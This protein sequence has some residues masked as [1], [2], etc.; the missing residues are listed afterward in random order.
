MS[1]EIDEDSR[2]SAGIF[3]AAFDLL[4]ERV[5]GDDD[6]AALAD[7]MA[8]FREHL[9]R[10]F[11]YRLKSGWRSARAVCWFKSSAHEHL[12]Q[13]WKMAKIL[14]RN[15]VFIWVIKAARP[16]YVLY[17]DDA[18]ILAEPFAEIRRVL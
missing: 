4:D 13:A 14:E 6:F 15:D 3:C 17:E 5:L 7:L 12:A 11:N 16:G 10:P 2:V 18:Q 9:N 8:W 1:G